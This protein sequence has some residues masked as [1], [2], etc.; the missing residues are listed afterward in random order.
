MRM[1]LIRVWS[2]SRKLRLSQVVRWQAKKEARSRQG[3]ASIN[4]L[5]RLCKPNR[6]T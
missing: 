4:L 2:P 6:L 3:R 5:G 1:I